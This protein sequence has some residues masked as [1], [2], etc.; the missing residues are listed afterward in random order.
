MFPEGG[1]PFFREI[2]PIY[3][4]IGAGLPDDAAWPRPGELGDERDQVEASGLFDIAH[5][6]Q[7]DW[8]RVYDAEG[9]IELLD[10][11]SGHI[12][13]QDR[14]RARLNGEIRRRVAK[15][16]DGLLR[17]HWGAVLHLAQRLDA[18]ECPDT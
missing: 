13:M 1:D 2:Q 3:D 5:V 18:L 11:F 12:S 4:E 8:Q 14:Q 10:T 16:P 9:Y 6:Q 15:R 7:F 17:R